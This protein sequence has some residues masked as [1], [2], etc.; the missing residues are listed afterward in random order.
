MGGISANRGDGGKLSP[1]QEYWIQP[2]LSD[3]QISFGT[4]CGAVEGRQIHQCRNLVEVFGE[5]AG[6]LASSTSANGKG[7]GETEEIL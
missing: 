3:V 5:D 6:G 7:N 2:I 1:E 4:S